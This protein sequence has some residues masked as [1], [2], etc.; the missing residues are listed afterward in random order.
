MQACIKQ[1]LGTREAFAHHIRP[2]PACTHIPKPC[3]GLCAE[4]APASTGMYRGVMAR[5]CAGCPRVYTGTM[6]MASSILGLSGLGPG[7]TERGGQRAGAVPRPANP[8]L[9]LPKNGGLSLWPF[10]HPFRVSSLT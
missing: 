3:L 6:E 7:S 5:T 8:N 1:L 2:S 4:T 9:P 10:K